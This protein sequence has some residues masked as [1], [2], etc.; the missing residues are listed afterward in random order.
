MSSTKE[1]IP[2]KPEDWGSWISFVRTRATKSRIWD[3]VNPS[4]TE[5]PVALEDPEVPEYD[6]P[7]D[8]KDFDH[9]AFKAQTR[10]YK[11]RLAEFER[12]NE[13]SGDH[14][15]CIQDTIPI[16]NLIFFLETEEPHPWN[17]LR[18][19]KR[20]FGP[21]DE[22][23]INFHIN[24]DSITPITEIESDKE[25]L[26]SVTQPIETRDEF[27]NVLSLL[28]LDPTLDPTEVLLLE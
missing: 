23:R 20:R 14:I 10:V 24:L 15:S 2:A 19:V 8:G 11:M 25:E 22:P 17:I 27:T 21:C 4:L 6:I 9:E 16:H 7:E 13:S 5:K 28:T 12:Q 1:V 3:L 18:A 26:D